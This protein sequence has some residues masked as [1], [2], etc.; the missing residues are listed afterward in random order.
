MQNLHVRAKLAVKLYFAFTI[1]CAS[2]LLLV[3]A[4][5][6][7][8]T[9]RGIE[10]EAFKRLDN[11]VAVNLHTFGYFKDNA[12]ASAQMFASHPRVIRFAN[13]QGDQDPAAIQDMMGIL[14]QN[15]LFKIY[16]SAG[17]LLVQRGSMPAGSVMIADPPSAGLQ[18]ALAGEAVKG[19]EPIGDGGL[20]VRGIAPIRNGADIVGAVLVGLH[21]DQAFADQ[22]RAITGLEVGIAAGD[23][24]KSTWLAQTI[25][26]AK[27]ARF[28]GDVQPSIVTAVR[29]SGKVLKQAVTID[30]QEHLAA[31]AP[32]FGDYD[33]FVGL[34][35][36]GEPSKPLKELTRRAQLFILGI[37]L[38]AAVLA[39][40][41]SSLLARTIT[42]PIRQL[43]EHATAVAHGNLE[44]RLNLKT[45][46]ELEQLAEA[47]NAMTKSLAIM[48]FN[49]Q[50][51]NPL[52]KLPGNLVIEAE[53]KRRI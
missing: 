12:L 14:E 6:T 40:V 5:G 51:A 35:F 47:F 15:Q 8:L 37:S 39:A 41:V 38:L 20:A 22:L 46:D 1:I 30:G 34:L 18:L 3:A 43:A 23:S 2:I 19:V 42:D 13:S 29:S 28:Q 52:T 21:L 27:G 49:D 26:T 17:H 9:T 7:L 24:R 10:A 44:E 25:R 48:K 4:I 36:I 53:V 45:G 11:D 32:L 31:F 33:Q 50:N 16:D